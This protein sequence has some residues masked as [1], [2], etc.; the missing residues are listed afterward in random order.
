MVQEPLIDD[1]RRTD[2]IEKLNQGVES[3]VITSLLLLIPA[4]RNSGEQSTIGT[5]SST[6]RR[7]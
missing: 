6:D 5:S 4:N 3:D 1:Q 7:R 2:Q